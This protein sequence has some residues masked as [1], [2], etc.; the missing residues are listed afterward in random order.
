MKKLL[1]CFT[2]FLVVG[3]S[4]TPVY[5]NT[6]LVKNSSKKPLNSLH[7]NG[8]Q[9]T[10][11]NPHI[12]ADIYE[13][14]CPQSVQLLNGEKS[15]E[16]KLF[17]Q[18]NKS[19]VEP[20]DPLLMDQW[21]LDTMNVRSFW[22]SSTAGDRKVVVAIIDS[23]MS[24]RHEDLQQNLGINF[25]EIPANGIDDDGNGYVDDYYGWDAVNNSGDPSDRFDHGTHV[26]GIIGASSNNDLGITGINWNVS[27]VPIKFIDDQGGGRTES[28]IRA[29]DYA[30][31]RGAKII[32]LS[33]GG[34]SRSPL[35]EEVMT[36]CR[37]KGILFVAAAGNESR[38]ND[39]TP[40]YP[41][42]FPIDNVISVAAINLHN[43]MASFS[44]WGAKSVHVAAPGESILSTVGE[45][46]YGFKDGTSMATPHISGV[47][48]LVWAQHPN[49]TYQ[50]VKNYI[51][52][53]CKS[54]EK[55]EFPVLCK[56]HFSF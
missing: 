46:R 35:L 43:E 28:A 38:D 4:A 36:R 7:V 37:E 17:T 12:G 44:N 53:H 1:C 40:T 29:I 54:G 45:A 2:F 52:G 8:C 48:A 5:A 11:L 19:Y 15:I 20:S 25:K 49:W 14:N 30:V 27:I 26:A 47:A 6:W 18:Q 13:A 33:W 34:T 56:G 39:I 22:Q 16:W 3:I 55:S 21:G 10:L 51:L 50:E 9:Y 32:N 23:G 41:A 31:A 24:F 42:S